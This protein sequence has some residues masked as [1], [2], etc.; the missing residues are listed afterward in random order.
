[1]IDIELN[2]LCKIELDI[3]DYYNRDIQ[4]SDWYDQNFLISYIFY[5]KFS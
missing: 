3:F 4:N 2:L 1:M 5:Q